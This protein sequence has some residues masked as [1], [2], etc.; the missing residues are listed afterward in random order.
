MEKNIGM[1]CQNVLKQDRDDIKVKA[2][3]QSPVYPNIFFTLRNCSAKKDIG[4]ALC[5]FA[6]TFI[7]SLSCFYIFW[8]AI[9]IS[10]SILMIFKSCF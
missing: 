5:I 6:Y 10:F 1:A 3:R 7:S 4:M 2:N 9:P 8:H